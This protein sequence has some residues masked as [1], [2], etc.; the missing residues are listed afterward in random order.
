MI[1]G[2]PSLVVG[3]DVGGTSTT[4]LFQLRGST[5]SV[6]IEEEGINLKVSGTDAVCS[7]LLR[8]LYGI[9]S[10]TNNTGTAVVCAG[11]AGAGS[12]EDRA[13]LAGQFHA[14]GDGNILL[15]HPDTLVA[16]EGAFEGGSGMLCI[17]GT[18]SNVSIRDNT[19]RI[20]S[21]GGWGPL[22]GDPASA[23][24]IGIAAL[25]YMARCTEPEGEGPINSH[26]DDILFKELKDQFALS[27]RDEILRFVYGPA[28]C[29]SGFSETP[30]II[31]PLV[32]SAAERGSS[33]SQK[34]ITDGIR[35]FLDQIV[36]L[37]AAVENVDQRFVLMGGLS[38]SLYFSEQFDLEM[39]R[40]LPG[41]KRTTPAA[42]PARG[43]LR[44]ANIFAAR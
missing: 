32:A 21:A 5:T 29:S 17:A 18:G 40:R 10:H 41:W 15:V 14:S 30:A 13:A 22:M 43:A 7:L 25:R 37:C 12:A 1:R 16:L 33:A 3:L 39:L 20:T 26:S 31:S 8:I 38:N 23:F 24:Q 27:T 2:K 6:E 19:G 42:S 36:R 35:A 28:P 34:I 11:I 4:G 44:L 9:R